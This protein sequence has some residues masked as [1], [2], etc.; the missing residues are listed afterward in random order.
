MSNDEKRP[1]CAKRAIGCGCSLVLA[2]FG[3]FMA[4][5]F[6]GTAHWMDGIRRVNKQTEQTAP[7]EPSK[8]KPKSGRRR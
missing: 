5:F 4:M 7:A 6:S 2:L 1:G 3:I 8:K